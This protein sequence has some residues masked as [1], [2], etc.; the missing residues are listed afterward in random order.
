MRTLDI[1]QYE[2]ARYIEQ[3]EDTYLD[4][5]GTSSSE[6][7]MSSDLVRWEPGVSSR[8]NSG[9]SLAFAVMFLRSLGASAF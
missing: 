7:Y 3:Y 4:A 8:E 6:L 2:D 5:S 9:V 1:Q